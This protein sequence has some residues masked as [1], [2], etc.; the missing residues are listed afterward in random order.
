MRL[1]RQPSMLVE[2]AHWTAQKVLL[3]KPPQRRIHGINIGNFINFSEFHSVSHAVA[4]EE[5]HFFETFDFGEGAIIDIGANLGIVSLLAARRYPN[6]RVIAIE[7]APSTYSALAANVEKNNTQVECLQ[8]A[9]SET[10]GKVEFAALEDARANAYIVKSGSTARST[11]EVPAR[12]LDTLIDKLGISHIALVKID[13]EGFEA[14]VL[15]GAPKVLN[16]IRPTAIYFEVCPKFSLRAGFAASEAA[17]LLVDAGYELY[18]IDE[19]F[20]LEPVKPAMAD[21]IVSANWLA[22]APDRIEQRGPA[23]LGGGAAA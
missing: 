17:Q 9:I 16:D 5:R 7:P 6:R 3:R 18:H 14:S 4:D 21:K 10:D 13:T 15:H 22:L 8:F 20:T 2:Y 1:A 19:R 12:R 23:R 11:I